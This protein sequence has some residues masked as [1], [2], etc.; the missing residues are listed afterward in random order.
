[1]RCVGKSFRQV[2]SGTLRLDRAGGLRK[3]DARKF[4]GRV[5][6]LGGEFCVTCE[7]R[8]A[9]GE[10][11]DIAAAGQFEQSQYFFC[12]RVD[13]CLSVDNGNRLYVYV[14]AREKE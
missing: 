5:A 11:R 14:R 1:M 10:D 4:V 13:V 7:R 6:P 3:S 9:A 2:L 8:F 12:S